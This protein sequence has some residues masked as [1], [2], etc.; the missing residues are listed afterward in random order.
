MYMYVYV[1]NESCFCT[2]HITCV[3][4]CVGGGGD[5]LLL[6]SF[7]HCLY[8]VPKCYLYCSSHMVSPRSN[9]IRSNKLF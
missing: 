5:F 8:T 7:Y 2:F 1:S 9:K 3:C 4:V 6:F